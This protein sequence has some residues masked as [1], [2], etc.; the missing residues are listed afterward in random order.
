MATVGRI[1]VDVIADTAEFVK[2]INRAVRKTDSFG[3]T[4]A[5]LGTR[6]ARSFA[7]GVTVAA[8]ALSALTLAGTR[9]ADELAKTS[10]KLGLAAKDLAGLRFAAE[11]TGVATRQL[12]MGLQRMVRRISEAAQGTGE[13]K[14]ALKELGLSAQELARQSPDEQ[15]RQVAD[16]MEGVATQSDKVRLGFKLFDAE[17][18]AL[19]NTL[20][21]GREQLD[22]FTKE[23]E[24]LG[25]TLGNKQ[26]KNIEAAADS[27]NR[28]AKAFSGLGQQLAAT[29]APAMKQ[30]A[31]S[32]ADFVAS[33][34][35][36]LPQMAA[37]A[38]AT[39]GISRAIKDLTGA[40][41]RAELEAVFDALGK[42]RAKLRELQKL[43]RSQAATRGRLG[44]GLNTQEIRQ[45]REA[46]EDFARLTLRSQQLQAAMR[47]GNA[48]AAA[49]SSTFIA[50]ARKNTEAALET[51][52]MANKAM[53]GMVA[54]W[55]R[56]EGA[57]AQIFSS[58]RTPIENFILRM[59]EA[60]EALK[61]GFIDEET[62]NRF[63]DQMLDKV[64]S[65]IEDMESASKKG[66]DE[67]R[68]AGKQAAR[69]TQQAFADF[70]FDPF[71]KG[72]KGMVRGFLDAVR[73]MLA[74][75]A[76]IQLFGFLGGL[77]GGT[78]KGVGTKSPAPPKAPK[79]STF[80]GAFA[81]GGSFPVGGVGGTDSQPVFF[82]ASPNETVTVTKPGQSPGGG[83][84]VNQNYHIEAGADWATLQQILPPLFEDN[85]MQTIAELTDMRSKG[86]F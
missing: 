26:L 4:M 24:R 71:D 36:S 22:A 51:M 74:N 83:I 21:A 40:E 27:G 70:L 80:A 69:D 14:A 63:R 20:A 3:K 54:G 59:N 43:F 60:R 52:A 9:T 86:D 5:K 11:Q 81:G 55:E 48:D 34:T 28:M 44:I 16:A 46:A 68:E 77:F 12:D 84:T 72:V 42:S 13:A 78:P 31:D 67:M 66:F 37:F 39:F 64:I 61:G 49:A 1:V 56:L 30:A 8:A 79:D 82:R 50:R 47:N 19:V 53:D 23:A 85:R 58:T 15:F 33:I 57:A 45:I 65:P 29:F 75:E 7:R 17:G 73:R 76:A 62:F 6:A 18:V 35:S 38:S 2:G 41:I 32:T 25:L 10:A